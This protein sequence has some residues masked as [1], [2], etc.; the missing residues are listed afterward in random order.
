MKGTW[1]QYQGHMDGYFYARLLKQIEN[2]VV[3]YRDA[4]MHAEH[5]HVTHI[6]KGSSLGNNQVAF[7]QAQRGSVL[8][9]LSQSSPNV[10]PIGHFQWKERLLEIE[11]QLRNLG[12]TDFT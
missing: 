3:A 2:D 11:E 1:L 8:D 7:L 4:L 6:M 5:L 9:M 12:V 10:D